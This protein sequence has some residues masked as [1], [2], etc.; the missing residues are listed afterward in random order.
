VNNGDRKGVNWT[1]GGGWADG[2]QDQYPDWVEIDF[3][4]SKTISQVVV[5]T[6]ADD[7]QHPVEPN[8][9]MTFTQFGIQDFTVQAWNGSAWQT[10]GTA[11]NNNL[12]KR[13]FNVAVTTTKIRVNVTRSMVSLSRITEIEAIGN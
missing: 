6:S 2:T 13:T 11:T 12:V 4:G 5:Y 8:D 7:W 3:N 10:L 1:A 9:T